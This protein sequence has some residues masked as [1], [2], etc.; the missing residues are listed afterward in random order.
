MN[1][2]TTGKEVMDVFESKKE[3][4]KMMSLIVKDDMIDKDEIEL[5]LEESSMEEYPDYYFL[6]L[7]IEEGISLY[8]II[9]LQKRIQ[10]LKHNKM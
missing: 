7:K 6:M 1:V 10:Y 5:Q 4:Q 9:N 2:F 8:S 3:A